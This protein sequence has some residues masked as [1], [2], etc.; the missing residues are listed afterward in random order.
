[1]R[2]PLH[3]GVIVRQDCIKPLNLS[4][5]ECANLLGVARQT[6]SNIAWAGTKDQGKTYYRRA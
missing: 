2:N 3:L 6:L 5:T 4:V 1:M